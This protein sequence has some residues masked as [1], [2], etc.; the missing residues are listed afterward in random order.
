MDQGDPWDSDWSA[1]Y[2]DGP[3]PG[4]ATCHPCGDIG[5]GQGT[6]GPIPPRKTNSPLRDI[7]A[8][9]HYYR[10]KEQ[11]ITAA[12]VKD[13]LTFQ[14]HTYQIFVDLSPLTVAKRRALKPAMPSDHVPLGIS[15][16][17]TL[18]PSGNI[19]CLPYSWGNTDS[20]AGPGPTGPYPAQG[21]ISQMINLPFL[22]K[23]AGC[24]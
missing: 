3:V 10:T 5:N 21:I 20:P 7:I 2:Y 9:F 12:R 1:S 16:L 19:I 24:R 18:Y 11:L 22:T 15:F 4:T 13:S 14:G 6:Q 8:K 23:I 17:G